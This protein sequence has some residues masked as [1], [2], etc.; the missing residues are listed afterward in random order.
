MVTFI[1]FIISIIKFIFVGEWDCSDGSDEERL[2]IIDHLSEH[3]S[4]LM[5]LTELKQKCYE[6]YRLNNTPF[7]DIC[8]LSYEYPCFRTNIDDIFN[9]EVHRPCI[10]LTQIG[11]GIIDCLTGL[12]ER[13][14]LQCSDR[15]M[16]GF[17]FQF[18][19]SLCV[20]Y[21]ALCNNLYPWKPDANI[22][23]D[24][25]CFHQKFKFKNSTNPDCKTL[26]SMMCLNDVCIKNTRC[27][28]KIECS[29]GEDEYR[30]LPENQSPQKYRLFKEMPLELKF[31][32]LRLQ[33]YPSSTQGLAKTPSSLFILNEKKNLLY[34]TPSPS[35]SRDYSK[36]KTVYEIVRDSLKNGE[37]TFEK[38]YLPFIC[39]RG[40]AIKYYTNQTVCFC[41]PSF[42]GSQCQYYSDRLTVVTHFDLNTYPSSINK[43]NIL[44]V[45][46]TFLFK[47]KL[48]IIMNFMLIH[49]YKLIISI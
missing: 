49:K 16:L 13:N 46:T 8:D 40:L 43:I 37:I 12:D 2:F 28:G 27:N 21:S 38:D 48:L 36:V 34:I 6:Q 7:F 11:D 24:S 10:N 26:N 47:M 4:K 1:F 33:N 17:H 20:P 32:P 15:G 23:Y 14:R 9:V 45:L 5:N 31:T 35:P 18:N 42:Y 41:P 3:N 30:C 39:N 22:A 29:H 44:K 19:D 25:V